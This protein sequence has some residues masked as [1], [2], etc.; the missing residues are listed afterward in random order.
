MNLISFLFS[1]PMDR[2]IAHRSIFSH[3][4]YVTRFS[5]L[6]LILSLYPFDGVQVHIPGEL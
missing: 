1:F 4:L 6:Q 2:A 5:P 3:R